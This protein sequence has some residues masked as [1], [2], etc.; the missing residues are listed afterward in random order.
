MV[1]E[2]SPPRDEDE[3]GDMDADGEE[4]DEGYGA[5]TQK[6]A[7][8]GNGALM[9]SIGQEGSPRGLKR[10]RDGSVREQ[11]ESG[12]SDIARAVTR[13]SGTAGLGNEADDVVLQTEDILGNLDTA[14]QEQQQTSLGGREEAITTA[15]GRLTKL[16]G[17]HSDATTETGSIGPQSDDGLARATYL[18]TLLL[19]LHDPHTNTSSKSF[20]RSQRAITAPGQPSKS[21]PLPGALLDWLNTRHNPLPDDFN[22]IHLH[23]PSP[24][25]HE[26]FWDFLGAE[27]LR[28]KLVRVIRLLRDAGWEHA[29]TALDDDSAAGPHGGY[30]GKQLENVEEVMARC[31]KVL[32]S[33]PAVRDNE[34][35]DVKGVEWEIF[36]Q[37]VRHA[38]KDLET[39]AKGNSRDDEG[40]ETLDDDDDDDL[41]KSSENVFAKSSASGAF[42]S[43][44]A[45]SR[46][47]SSRVPWAIYENLKVLYGVMLGGEEIVDYAQDWVEASILFTVWWDGKEGD[48]AALGTSLAGGRKSTR[49]SV[50]ASRTREVDVSPLTAYRRKL[51]QM[52][53]MVTAQIEEPAFQPDTLDAVQVGLVCVM[54]NEVEA[55][56]GLLR[57]WDPT[58]ARAVVEVAA[59]GGWLPLARPNGHDGL[60]RKGFSSE[61]LMVLSHGPPVTSSAVLSGCRSR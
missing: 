11:G 41:G 46:R 2:S 49:K 58:V 34:S 45:A 6:D 24:S 31:I 53:R 15:I 26:G 57:T 28:G 60:L 36:R 25:A 20:A 55:V 30:Q 17:Q 51:G 44:A 59:L 1:P 13:D 23:Q 7:G 33:C 54:E 52:F 27:L 19:Q 48:P 50:H 32:E 4:V 16:W 37:R 35:W 18:S 10:S 12:M 47:A 40:E 42:G 29:A 9:S 43:M 39:F 5:Y 3:E 38:I 56:V 8:L 22:A 21:A 61:D 14:V